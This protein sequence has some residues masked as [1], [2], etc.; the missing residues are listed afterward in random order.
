MSISQNIIYFAYGSNMS[1][2]RLRKRVPSATAVDKGFVTHRRLVFDKL[3]TDGSGKCDIQPTSR[4]TDRVFGVLFEFDKSEL[5]ALDAA[6][7]LGHGYNHEYVRVITESGITRALTYVAAMK[8]GGLRPYCW[9]RALV[10]AGATEHDLP[11][12]HRDAI[13]AVSCIPDPDE[14]RR[15]RNESI[16]SQTAVLP[17]GQDL[18]F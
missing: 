3:G 1:T 14:E 6:E 4:E 5:P 18:A 17:H 7:G 11:D 12:E 10:L 8:E 9:Y 15:A 2:V 16:L 13:R